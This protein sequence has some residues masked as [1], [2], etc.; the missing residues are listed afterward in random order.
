MGQPYSGLNLPWLMADITEEQ[1]NPASLVAKSMA[2]RLKE[3][4]KGPKKGK[5]P[6]YSEVRKPYYKNN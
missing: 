3:A 4:Y 5:K 1:R 2:Y 6:P